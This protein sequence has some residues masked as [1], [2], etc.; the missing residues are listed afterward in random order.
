MISELGREK[1]GGEEWDLNSRLRAHS[2]LWDLD[3]I[4]WGCSRSG[5]FLR[6]QVHPMA[7]LYSGMSLCGSKRGPW[8]ATERSLH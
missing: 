8:P 5:P 7:R 3:E 2:G 1:I 4:C 6:A